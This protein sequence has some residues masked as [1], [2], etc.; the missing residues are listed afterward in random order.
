MPIVLPD[1][2]ATTLRISLPPGFPAPASPPSLSL[3]APGVRHT[4][5]D[6]ASG[7]VTCP[8]LARWGGGA[9]GGGGGGGGGKVAEAVQEVLA[10]LGASVV[11]DRKS[12]V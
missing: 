1:G 11:G 5:V 2:T 8:A 10:G 4:W 6:A 7:R 9:G 3:A 12:V